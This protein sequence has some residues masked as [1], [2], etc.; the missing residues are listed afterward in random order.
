MTV[1]SFLV[2]FAGLIVA[3]ILAH[4]LSPAGRGEMAAALAPAALMLAAA[5]FGLPDALTYYLAKRPGSTRRALVWGTLITLALG[6]VCL[7]VVWAALPF[8]S[9]GKPGLANNI[10]IA[11]AFTIPALAVG[12]FRGAAT[13]RQMWR[14]VTFERLIL[15][16]LRIACFV[17]LWLT[18]N[19]T[20]FSAVLVSVVLPIIGGVVYLV[21]LNKPKN[22]FDDPE[23]S[24]RVL[25]SIMGYGSKVWLGSIASMLLDRITP[26]I[27]APLSSVEDLGLFTVANT[28][29]DV[30]LIV[31]L[32]IQGALFGV[33]SRTADATKLTTTARLT[34]LAA[35]CGCIPIGATLPFWIGPLFGT[36]FQAATVPTLILLVSSI[37]CVPGLMASGG[38]SAWGR[39]GLRSVGLAIAF[40]ITLISLVVLVPL[41]GVYG[42]AITNLISN[43][44][45]TITMVKLASNVIGVPATD[46]F[47]IRKADFVRGKDEANALFTALSKIVRRT[48]VSAN[49]KTAR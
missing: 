31:A 39:P 10:L 40:G 28:I 12:V 29:S 2:P 1:S 4:A 42:A 30:P 9:V 5:T 20:V 15:T 45:F 18:G 24:D 22:E 6:I 35:I 32:A 27:M 13:G 16:G 36:Q 23:V 43:S 49:E 46:F 37:S 44:V 14:V 26:L 47:A 41:L 38:L 25:S 34:T 19:L 48:P 3:P 7:F 8:L 33:N 21:L 11:T 17:T